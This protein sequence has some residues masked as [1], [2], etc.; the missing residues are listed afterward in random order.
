[1]EDSLIVI[2]RGTPRKTI[3]QSQ[4]RDLKVKRLSLEFGLIHGRALYGID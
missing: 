3:G 1:M 4:P 2:E